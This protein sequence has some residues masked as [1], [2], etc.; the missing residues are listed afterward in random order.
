MRTRQCTLTLLTILL[1]IGGCKSQ[2]PVYQLP[3]IRHI[4]R[5]HT[6][7]VPFF[8]PG[9]SLS[10]RAFFECDSLNNVLM[11]ELEEG[12]SGRVNSKVGFKNG[13]LDYNANVQPDTVYLPSDSVFV[14]KEIPYPVEV[15][16]I[17]IRQTKIQ[18]F[19]YLIG[20]IATTAM[21]VWL[22]MKLGL[23]RFF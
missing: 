7:L 10:L 11:T 18:R 3:P 21:V 20:I 8:I 16:K 9:D 19:F 4:E 1:I 6:R 14:E 15:D 2:Q 23:K 17:V 12:K 22:I 5:T 13:A